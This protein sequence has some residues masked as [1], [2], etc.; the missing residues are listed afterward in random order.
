MSNISLRL[1]AGAAVVVSGG[2]TFSR[3][4][5]KSPL[6]MPSWLLTVILTKSIS[7][8]VSLR[9]KRLPLCRGKFGR[10]VY[11]ISSSY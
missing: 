3:H 5:S 11:G 2:F 9:L 1:D 4:A 7:V 8:R 10:T 6:Y